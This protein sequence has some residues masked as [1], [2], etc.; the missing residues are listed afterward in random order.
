MDNVRYTDIELL[1]LFWLI[2]KRHIIK[3]FTRK[4]QH[5]FNNLD[6]I[7][8]ETGEYNGRYSKELTTQ[9]I[10]KVGYIA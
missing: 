1:R 2:F 3:Q 10:T 8:D 7:T 9:N 6:A 4:V 5:Y